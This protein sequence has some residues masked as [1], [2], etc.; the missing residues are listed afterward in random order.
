MVASPTQLVIGSGLEDGCFG[1]HR[2]AVVGNVALVVGLCLVT[3]VAAYRRHVAL[4]RVTSWLCLVAFFVLLPPTMTSGVFV[5]LHDGSAWPVLGAAGAVAVVAVTVVSM[6]CV[7]R[8]CPGAV[9]RMLS[10]RRT[11]RRVTGRKGA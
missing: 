3:L 4:M 10:S 5:A 7:Y 6:I 9:L 8:S 11:G 2:G 1:L